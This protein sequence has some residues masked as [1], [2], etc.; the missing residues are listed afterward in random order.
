MSIKSS[1]YKP[2][3]N[4]TSSKAEAVNAHRPRDQKNKLLDLNLIYLTV[5]TIARA[6]ESKD[7]NNVDAS[8]NS[9]EVK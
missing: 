5:I 9:S 4:I 6:S 3:A 2:N 7:I 1:E 8:I